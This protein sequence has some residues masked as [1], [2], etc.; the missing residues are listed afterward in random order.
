VNFAAR[1]SEKKVVKVL[2]NIQG[3]AD[4]TKN[5]HLKL[6]SSSKNS[7]KICQKTIDFC[8]CG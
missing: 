4:E 1:L 2:L 7:S 3:T 8:A 5:K 6:Q